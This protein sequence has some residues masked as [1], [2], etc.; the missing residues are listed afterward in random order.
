MALLSALSLLFR[1][2]ICAQLSPDGQHLRPHRVRCG[3]SQV[4]T[5]IRRISLCQTSPGHLGCACP[6]SDESNEA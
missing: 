5:E 6:D 4:P 3:K 1:S 2:L